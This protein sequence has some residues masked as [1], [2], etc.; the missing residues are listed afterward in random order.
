MDSRTQGLRPR[1]STQKNFEDRSSRGQGLKYSK[2]IG[3]G[4]N[5]EVFSKKKKVFAKTVANLFPQ[6]TGDLKKQKVFALKFANFHKIQ[7]LFQKF[8]SQ[9]LL[10][11]PRRNN[12]AHNLGSFS[13]SQKIV[14]ISRKEHFRGLACF[15]AK[16]LT[17]GA[18]DFKLCPRGQRRPRGL[19]LW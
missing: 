18:K 10:R 3:Q 5:A 8:F 12:I 7:A 15:K 4:H 6:Q 2:L 19:H 14:L 16:D 9:V 13:T 11:A 1:P 17:F